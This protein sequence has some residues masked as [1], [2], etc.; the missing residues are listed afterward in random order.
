[1]FKNPTVYLFIK[2][3]KISTNYPSINHLYHLSNK[4]WEGRSPIYHRPKT[5]KNNNEHQVFSWPNMHVLRLWEKTRAPRRNPHRPQLN[6]MFKFRGG[7][8]NHCTNVLPLIIKSLS[9][10][11]YFSLHLH[12]TDSVWWFGDALNKLQYVFLWW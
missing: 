10:F 1:M 7:S 2:R 8:A 3:T 5:E 4:D 6:G 11:F 9:Y 12:F